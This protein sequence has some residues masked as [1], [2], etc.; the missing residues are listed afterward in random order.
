MSIIVYRD[1]VIA[2]D[3]GV[4]QDELFCG[5]TTK[6]AK[7]PKGKLG[8]MCGSVSDLQKFVSWVKSDCKGEPSIT[9]SG[10]EGI[11]IKPNGE[12]SVYSVDG[13]ILLGESDF[14][15]IG[16]GQSIAFGALE[17]GADA[18]RAVEICVIRHIYCAYPIVSLSRKRD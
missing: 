9:S 6:I 8:G 17:C 11:L 5:I 13:Y 10:S 1:G 18:I 2:S 4:F 7:S 3:S 14:Y 15:A 12:V 16:S